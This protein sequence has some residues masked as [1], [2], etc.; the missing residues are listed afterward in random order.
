MVAP[1]KKIDVF[2]S[3]A[4]GDG[5][6]RYNDIRQQLKVI[7]EGTGLADVYLFEDEEASTLSA[8]KHY[9][10]QLEDSDLCIFLIDNADGVFAG[11]QKEIHCA[12][13]HNIK[14]LYYFCDQQSKDETPL[15]KSL[16]GVNFVKTKVI[17][18][19][20]DFIEHGAQ[21]LI[22]DIILIYKSYCSGRLIAID[23]DEITD[24]QGF[25]LNDGNARTALVAP[26]TIINNADKCKAYF[27]KLVTNHDPKIEKTN[28]LDD[29]LAQAL[30]ILF[31]N[32]T[33]NNYNVSLFLKE[34]QKHQ[35]PEHFEVTSRRWDA[36]Q[37]YFLGDLQSSVSLLEDALRRAKDLDLPDWLI[38]DIL[39]DLRNQ[40]G[41]LEESRNTYIV[42]DEV[43]KEINQSDQ[44]I[45]Y[46]L[47]DRI[48][49]NLNEKYI[50]GALKEKI[51]SPF[52][53]SMGHSVDQ[54]TDLLAS[55]Y[56][57]AMY[58]GSLTHLVLIYNQIKLL[59]FYL[60]QMF[61][62]WS[63]RLLL[64][65]TSI[66]N[67]SAKEIDGIT[68]AFPEILV[69]LSNRDAAEIVSFCNNKV[70]PY[71]RLIA[72]L[73]ALKVV[74]YYLD[75]PGFAALTGEIF[76]EIN[77]WFQDQNKNVLVG[78]S[79]F[80][81]LGNVAE[82]L[83]QDV[84]AE[85]CCQAIENSLK[86][87]YDDMFEFISGHI[88]INQLSDLV[89]QRLLS[90]IISVICDG[91]TAQ[92]TNNL[93]HALIKFRKQS[94]AHTDE[95][96]KVIS[97]RLS[98]FYGGIYKLE[99]T[100]DEERDLPEYLLK[101]IKSIN[102]RNAEQGQNG[103]FFSYVD[104]PHLIIRSILINSGFGCNEE[105]IDSA[106]RAASETLLSDKQDMETKCEAIDLLTYLS[107]KYPELLI[108]NNAIVE[109]LRD[110]RVIIQTGYGPMFLSN[111]T[112]EVLKFS[113]LFLYHC[114]GE[115]TWLQMIEILPLIQN[116][117]SAQI[118]VSK[119]I[120]SF[121]EVDETGPIDV[122]LESIF[123]QQALIWAASENL[124]VRWHAIKILI[125]LL[126]NPSNA[127]IVCGQLVRSVDVDNLYIKNLILR[128]SSKSE[129]IDT[130][131]RDYIFLKCEIDSNYMVRKTCSEL[132]NGKHAK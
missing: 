52:T 82:R 70:I 28:A 120:Q 37:A 10:Y 106:F 69:K 45:Y 43:Q 3:S 114:F 54:Y 115:K 29:W 103:T 124:N 58:N 100:E 36:I 46:P 126:R 125:L 5:R 30:P 123:L 40:R 49:N 2:I 85:I 76:A 122:N 109:T 38:K 79:L 50:Q 7:I 84:M 97:E 61:D 119:M 15:Q 39:I 47:I 32:K 59:S 71:Q 130:A 86:R 77:I 108:R 91:E 67:Y 24:T 110:Q 64:L 92:N 25:K 13:K 80:S 129:L 101:Y 112:D 132:K 33:I 102:E 31:E 88:D 63:V 75:D 8:G 21:G 73:Y 41:Y 127:D 42:D 1:N 53:V 35:S 51:K 118:R 99:T 105:V 68:K 107:M 94:R 14:S 81:C 95:L 56:V 44:A 34:L 11:V 93:S 9:L 113:S 117:I 111:I 4:C 98:E 22:D 74:G 18:S 72:R 55:S 78:G 16:K 12:N 90:N 104:R 20:E 19:F 60:C 131:T 27:H 116:D 128:E 57:V 26:K 17:H 66:I 121:L 65:K 89:R 23:S 96:D 62:D 48:Q 6:E 83:D 87:F